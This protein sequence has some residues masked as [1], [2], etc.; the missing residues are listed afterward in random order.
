MSVSSQRFIARH[1]APRV[2]LQYTIEVSGSDK[3]VEL[4]FVTGVLADLSGNSSVVAKPDMVDRKFLDIDMDNFDKRMAGIEPSVSM[5]VVNK[6]GGEEDGDE[7]SVHL[8]F[9]KMDDF[10]PAA[11]VRQVPRLA[12]L[13]DS[14]QLL[15]N[16]QSY[17]DGRDGARAL[18]E[19]ILRNAKLMSALALLGDQQIADGEG[20]AETDVRFR[21]AGLGQRHFR[22]D[23]RPLPKCRYRTGRS[24]YARQREI[25]T[26]N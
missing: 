12:K 7:L 17:M 11:V 3:V 13:F 18:V 4:P 19:N 25:P 24:R 6:L 16:L 21:S 15:R 22:R 5:K 26:A 1:R 9:T 8:K 2:H 23:R 14:R 20:A 10:S